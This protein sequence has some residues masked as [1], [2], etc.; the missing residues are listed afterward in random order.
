MYANPITTGAHLLVSIHAGAL[1]ADMD[2]WN[3]N[4]KNLATGV[5]W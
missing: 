3:T 2:S 4:N 5:S 1:K